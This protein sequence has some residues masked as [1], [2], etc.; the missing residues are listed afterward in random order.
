[1]G[2][3]RVVST[4]NPECW[5]K[6]AKRNVL[7][8]LE[9]TTWELVVYH[10]GEQPGLQHP[11]LIWRQFE[12]IPGATDFI[13][14]ARGFPPACGKF[15]NGYDYNFDAAKF[16]AKVYAQCDAAVEAGEY[17]LWLDSDVEVTQTCLSAV[18]DKA[19]H[20]TAVGRYER[21]GYHSE[22]GIVCWDLRRDVCDR[23]FTAYRR[24]Y[25]TRRIYTLP[26]GWHDC[27][28]LDAIVDSLH[29][30]CVN[31]T[32]AQPNQLAVVPGSELGTYMRHDKGMRKHAA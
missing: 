24:L 27:W 8:W 18:I 21:P 7:S 31:W 12:D 30:P 9:H 29:M 14:E 3:V 28:A 2:D 32:R 5:D 10:E 13:R 11:R 16:S 22:T 6:F 20:G 25:D 19:M 15:A 23:F 26:R 1:M 4:F 17:L